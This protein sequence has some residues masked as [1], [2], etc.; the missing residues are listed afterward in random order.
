MAGF[1]LILGEENH[2]RVRVGEV[3]RKQTEKNG[4]ATHL[5]GRERDPR[6]FAI[7]WME[8]QLRL[9][10]LFAD[11]GLMLHGSDFPY[12]KV[13]MRGNGCYAEEPPC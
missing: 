13:V 11:L 6:S 3:V 10:M 1:Q 8:K 9:Q 7:V 4:T 5:K 12:R 2:C